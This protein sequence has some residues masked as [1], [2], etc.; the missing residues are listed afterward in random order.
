MATEIIPAQTTDLSIPGMLT[1]TSLTLPETLDIQSWLTIGE[2]L[3]YVQGAIMWWLGD[4]L[5]FGERKYGEMYSQALDVTGYSLQTLQNAAWVG[6]ALES[7]IRIEDLS[8]NHHQLLAS[9]EWADTREDWLALAA[10]E[11]W[12]VAKLRAALREDEKRRAL[13]AIAAQRV[14]RPLSP[15]LASASWETWLPTQPECDLLLTDP[16]YSTDV[17]DIGA[18]ARAWLPEALQHVKATGRAYVCIGSYP[19][20][21]QA[22]LEADR[23][24]MTLADVLV[25]CYNN[26]KG[27]APKDTYSRNYQ[28]ILHFKGAIAPPLDR[29]LTAEAEACQ[30]INAPGGFGESETRFHA[31]QKPTSLAEMYIR[32][33]TRQGELV[34]DPFAGTGTFLLAAAGLGRSASGCDLDPDMVAIAEQRGCEVV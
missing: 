24:G 23:A 26:T 30:V 21:L 3:R 4:W 27:A 34:L 2:R 20:E 12:S 14:D 7:S 25:W 18:F 17:E 9:T 32:H 13:A 19:E 6:R 33:A 28:V 16:P 11:K 5:N 8:W 1:P 10:E 22:Y 31:W 29:G 15:R